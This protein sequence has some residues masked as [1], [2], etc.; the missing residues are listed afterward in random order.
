MTTNPKQLRAGRFAVEFSNAEV[1][2]LAAVTAPGETINAYIRRVTLASLDSN[3]D[4]PHVETV[5]MAPYKGLN[6]PGAVE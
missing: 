3:K 1:R 2:K 5:T 4:R 6:V